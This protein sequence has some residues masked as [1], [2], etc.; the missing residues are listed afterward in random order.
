MGALASLARK[1]GLLLVEDCAQAHGAEFEGRPVGGFGDV[2][3]WSFCQDKIMSTGGEGGMITTDDDGVHNRTWQL[4][5]H[6]KSRAKVETPRPYPS[7]AYVHDAIG[8]NARLTGPQAA[9]GRV[10]LARLPDW[11]AR[12]ARNARALAEALGDLPALSMAWPPAGVTHAWYKFYVRLDPNCLR[13][14]WS[15]DDVIRAVRAEG[16]PCASGICPEIYKEGAFDGLGVRPAIA[17][18][19]AQRLGAESLMFPVHPTLEP[20]DMA[21]IAEALRK[22]LRVAAV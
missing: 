5:D 22:V 15:R 2:A 12:R 7:F 4:K 14:G 3:A 21:D 18:P 11:R 8:T 16:V 17:L 20:G 1:R 10:Q 19:E 6:G 13:A 9:I